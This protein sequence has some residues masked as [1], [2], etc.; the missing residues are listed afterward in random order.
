MRLRGLLDVRRCVAPTGGLRRAALVSGAKQVG[1][2]GLCCQKKYRCVSVSVPRA[3]E[4]VSRLCT[5][6]RAHHIHIFSL[7]HHAGKH[8]KSQQVLGYPMFFVLLRSKDLCYTFY[9]CRNG[10]VQRGT[11]SQCKILGSSFSSELY[12]SIGKLM[13]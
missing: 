12:I 11:R 9:T 2:R 13:A 5:R 1:P 10:Q 4:T 3:G 6:R 8:F 7:I